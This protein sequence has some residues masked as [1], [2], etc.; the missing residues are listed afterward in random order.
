MMSILAS[1][2]RSHLAQPQRLT[3]PWPFLPAHAEAPKSRAARAWFR[4]APN[5]ESSLSKSACRVGESPDRAV[6]RCGHERFGIA[7]ALFRTATPPGFGRPVASRAE[8]S[9]A[10]V[11]KD[12]EARCTESCPPLSFRSQLPT[13]SS[14]RSRPDLKLAQYISPY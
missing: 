5:P 4:S 11:D 14:K 8:K 13:K 10:P 12:L 7:R 6:G 1:L 3:R 9:P 2:A